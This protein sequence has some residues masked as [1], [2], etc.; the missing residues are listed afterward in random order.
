M[1]FYL[2]LSFNCQLKYLQEKLKIG[3]KYLLVDE[4]FWPFE[5]KYLLFHEYYVWAVCN[6]VRAPT[7][8]L[9]MCKSD[10]FLWSTGY[11]RFEMLVWC[12]TRSPFVQDSF[13][14]VGI[15][16]VLQGAAWVS[17]ERQNVYISA[18]LVFALDISQV[19]WL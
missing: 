19:F 7:F 11:I 8:A 13:S 1:S 17:A 16:K 5:K 15:G 2:N 10:G 12:E 3:V 9:I 14:C 18:G 6:L 4:I